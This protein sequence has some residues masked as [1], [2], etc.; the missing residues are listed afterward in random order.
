[1]LDIVKV[2]VRGLVEYVYRS[3]SIDSRFRTAST[4]AE[5]TRAHQK[6]QQTYAESDQKE[7]FVQ[8]EMVQDNLS[9]L[10]EGR[11]DG[12]LFSDDEVT[13]DEIKSTSRDLNTIEEDTYPVHWA[14]AKVYACIYASDHGLNAIHVQL[15]YVQVE[16]QEKKRFKKV[17]FL[18]ELK[19]FLE[20]TVKVYAPYAQLLVSHRKERD[21]SIKELPFPFDRYREGQRKLAGAVYTTIAEGK[22]LFAQAPT[23]IGKTMSTTFPAVKAIGEGLMQRFFY[24]TAKTITREAAEEAFLLMQEKGLRL[25]TV[26]LTA[27][28]KMCLKD[29]AVCQKEYCEFADGYYDRVNGAVLDILANETVI[30]RRTIQEYAIKHRLCPFEFSIDL[31]Y[32]AD[33]VICDYNYVFD[34]RVSLKRFFEEQKKQTALLV[35]EAHNLVDRGREMY[36]AEIYKSAFLNVSREYKGSNAE[37]QRAAKTVNDFGLSMKKR[38]GDARSLV[39]NDKPEELIELL[40]TFIV[41]AEKELL[42][43]KEGEGQQLLLDTYFA[44]QSFI[45]ISKLYDQRYVT[46][47]EYERSEVKIKMFCLDPSALLQQMGKSYRSSIF[48]SATFTPIDYYKDMIGFRD[49]DYALAIPSPFEREQLQIYIQPLSTRYRDREKTREPIADMIYQVVKENKGNFL[50]FFPSYQYMNDVYEQFLNEDFPLKSIVQSTGM[51]EEER[52]QFLNSFQADTQETLIG[53]AV[54]G[55]IF[56]EGVD[57]VGDRLNG[58]IV[59]GVGLPQLGLERNIIKDYFSSRGKNGYNYSYVYPGI[60]KVLQAGGRLIR[61]ETDRGTIVLV[62]DRF[63]TRQ[64]QALL[65]YEWQDF[66]I[67][68]PERTN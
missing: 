52:E 48:F 62:D 1:M 16:T 24:L 55:G 60:N 7:V 31:A 53:F 51:S 39:M 54:M 36:S 56:S 23:G 33:A 6:I 34:P 3:G 25:H 9:F 15:T 49:E 58:V 17:F 46:Y 27:K 18:D 13:I 59:V 67:L 29:K 47:A 42:I 26:T 19:L 22:N 21:Y 2:S 8:I 40:E 32:G 20:E 64:Y 37:L 5:G 45:R 28:D 14:Q 43:Q 30:H 65:P 38:C 41:S 66:T 10:I 11:C 50:V 4:L 63:L 44:A 57:L 61:S 35:D 12:L 68:K